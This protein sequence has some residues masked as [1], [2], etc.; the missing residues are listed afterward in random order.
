MCCKTCFLF[1]LI[2]F[3][4]RNIHF[5]YFLITNEEGANMFLQNVGNAA[6]I[7]VLLSLSLFTIIVKA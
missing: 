2:R 3:H 5:G 6:S 1:R 4:I 7:N